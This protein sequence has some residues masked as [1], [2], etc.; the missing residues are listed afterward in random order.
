MLHKSNNVSERK[1]K[2]EYTISSGVTKHKTSHGP[3][4]APHLERWARYFRRRYTIKLLEN[5]MDSKIT[6]S[7]HCSLERSY[8]VSI[9]LNVCLISSKVQH[10]NKCLLLDIKTFKNKIIFLYICL[11]LGHISSATNFLS[12]HIHKKLLT[13]PSFEI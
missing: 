7:Y 11:M 1:L 13:K 9:E 5:Y 10:K 3:S 6:K 2:K 4:S 8:T 12:L